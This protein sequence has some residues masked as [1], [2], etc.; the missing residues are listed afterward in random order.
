VYFT[1][2]GVLILKTFQ[3]VTALAALAASLLAAQV[4]D[5]QQVVYVQGPPP[6]PVYAQ[7]P[8]QPAPMAIP[9]QGEAADHG[10]FRG[11]IQL[12][13]GLFKPPSGALG[14]IGPAGQIGWQINN[15]IGVYAV[16]GFDILF[17]SAGGLEIGSAV[18]VDF[19]ILDDQLTVGG[20]PEFGAFAYFGST[21]A[22][23][24]AGYG[25]RLRA[26]YN[27]FISKG[28]DGVRRKALVVGLDLRFI[29]GPEATAAADCG[30]GCGASGVGSSSASTTGFTFAPLLSVGY[31]AF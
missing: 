18:M 15:L 7:G 12:E 16:P 6:G 3:C 31:V 23:G 17:G 20:G 25:G 26:Q 27:A 28:P 21:A 24:G 30:L 2:K 8:Y 19:T 1:A 4:A 10:R 13:G 14:A 29:I 11:G 5:A 9:P 22:G